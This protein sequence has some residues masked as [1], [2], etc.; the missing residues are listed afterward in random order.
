MAEPSSAPFDALAL[1]MAFAVAWTDAAQQMTRASLL[2]WSRMA[3]TCEQAGQAW[4]AL[5]RQ[6][7]DLE[8]FGTR[9]LTDGAGQLLQ[10][11]LQA[12]EGGAESLLNAAEDT[13]AQATKGRLVPLPE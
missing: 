3:T 9:A 12:L 2:A 7:I 1:P 13:L 4:A 10:T 6:A 8:G 5:A 11:E